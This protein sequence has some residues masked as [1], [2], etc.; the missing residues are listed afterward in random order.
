MNRPFLCLSLLILGFAAC[1][2]APD[3]DEDLLAI[4]KKHPIENEPPRKLGNLPEFALTDHSGSPFTRESLKGKAWI[5]D[6]VFTRCGSTCPMQTAKK[7]ELQE[8]LRQLP[9]WKDIGLLTFT[10][11]PEFDTPEVLS[12]Y[13]KRHNAD[14]DHWKF[15]TGTR[16]ALWNLS[17]HGFKLDV[18]EDAKNTAMPIYHS[19]RFVLI[20]RNGEIRG[21]HDGLKEDGLAKIEKDLMTILVEGQ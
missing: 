7:A 3:D 14:P 8:K 16:D 21:Y 1:Y 15:V 6:F 12:A 2:K 11:D 9:Q 13:A 5:A 18:G 17:K 20:D 10:V 4:V 19:S